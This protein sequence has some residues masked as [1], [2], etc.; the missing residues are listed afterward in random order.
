MAGK[1]AATDLV[2]CVWDQWTS[3]CSFNQFLNM[4][5][6]TKIE[7]TR[8][9]GEFTVCP[10]HCNRQKTLHGGLTA[11][12]FEDL[13]AMAMVSRG[14]NPETPPGRAASLKISYMAPAKLGDLVEIEA[15]T[16]RA[17]KTVA[18]LDCILRLKKDGK[19]LAKGSQVRTFIPDDKKKA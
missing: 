15:A 19:I 6:L 5:K 13:T 18:Y 11:T 8:V 10:E 4:V 3:T 16:I 17:G 9:V 7:T 14:I 2:K 12:I 1:K